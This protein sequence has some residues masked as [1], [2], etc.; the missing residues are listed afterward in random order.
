MAVCVFCRF[1]CETCTQRHRTECSMI[2]V[3]WYTRGANKSMKITRILPICAILLTIGIGPA[4]AQ[5]QG[6][7]GKGPAGPGMTL[8]SPAFADGSVIPNKYTQAESNPISPKLEWTNVP[9]NTASFVLIMH[10]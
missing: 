2:G 8:T 1:R 4:A 7:K 3:F 9:P 10:D 5:D 6:K